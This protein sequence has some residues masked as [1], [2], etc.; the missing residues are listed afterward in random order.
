MLDNYASRIRFVRSLTKL[1]REAFEEKYGI[2]RNTLKSWELGINTLTEKSAKGLSDAINEEGFSCSPQ[3]LIF[4]QGSMP[5]SLTEADDELLLNDINQQSKIIYEA[6]YFKKNNPNSIINIITDESMQPN[7]NPGDY[8]GGIKINFEKNL[9]GIIGSSC[10]IILQS[11]IVLV[12]KLL[13][14]KNEHILL[15]PINIQY[16][17]DIIKKEDILCI[18]SIIWH[19]TT[20]RRLTNES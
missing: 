13:R 20:F 1:S 11:E 8:V 19:R 15:C 2:N 10:I 18:A 6:D 12:R 4:G 17:A 7:Y 3:W 16:E 9:I 14:G 5:R